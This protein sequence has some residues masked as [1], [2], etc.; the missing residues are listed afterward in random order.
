MTECG[1]RY[2]PAP[3]WNGKMRWLFYCFWLYAKSFVSENKITTIM[4]SSTTVKP[5]IEKPD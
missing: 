1:L 4:V 2:C 5:A 3:L